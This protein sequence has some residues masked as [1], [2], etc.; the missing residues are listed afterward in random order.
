MSDHLKGAL[1]HYAQNQW[2]IFPCSEF[3]KPVFKNNL[4]QA[5]SDLALLEDWFFK[6]FPKSKPALSCARS[7]L[8]VVDVDVKNGGLD[9]WEGLCAKN[10]DPQTLMQRSASGGCHYVF[11]SKPGVLY[12]GQIA[13]G[14]DIKW[15]GYIILSPAI[16]NKNNKPY[17]WERILPVADYPEWVAQLIEKKGKEQTSISEKVSSSYIAKLIGV[18]KN[19]K[20]LDYHTWLRAGFAVH[21]ALPNEEGLSLWIDLSMGNSYKEGDEEKCR[22]MWSSFSNDKETPFTARSLP[23]LIRDCGLVVP[24]PDLEQDKR[25]L[26]ELQAQKVLEKKKEYKNAGTYFIQE[27]EQKVSWE[28]AKTVE[29]INA[30]GFIFAKLSGSNVFKVEHGD[31]DTVELKAFSAHDFLKQTAPYIYKYI[32]LTQKIRTINAGEVWLNSINRKT[33]KNFIFAEHNREGYYNL[34]EPLPTP[35]IVGEPALILKFIKESLCNGDSEKSEWLLDFLAH[36]I[37][38]PFEKVSVVP[39]HI[40][41]QGG[42]KG[43]LYDNVMRLILGRYFKCVTRMGVL[44]QQFNFHLSNK[45]LTYVDEATWGGNHKEAAALK[46]FSTNVTMTVEIKG[47]A[48]Y[49][50]KNFSRYVIASNNPKCINLEDGNRRYVVIE[51]SDTLAS[52]N[53]FFDPI[54][55]AVMA[56]DGIEVSKFHGYLLGRDISNFKAHQILKNNT[57]G[58]EAKT[59][60][61]VSGFWM[62]MMQ[63]PERPLWDKI[64]LK[65]KSVYQAFKDWKKL[66]DHHDRSIAIGSFWKKTKKLIPCVISKQIWSD[67]RNDQY[68]IIRP[69]DFFQKL[70]SSLVIDFPKNFDERPFEIPEEESLG[71]IF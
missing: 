35:T 68:W 28:E 66:V 49:E 62:D 1:A 64:G 60:D 63:Y 52:D 61:A 24:A 38:R 37:Q 54:W 59:Q 44:L 65:Q 67:K 47:G 31:D 22:K 33:I 45:L 14:I 10:S 51:G 29:G 43:L 56:P 46:T 39:V 70:C 30:Q 41:K 57:A 6:D 4:D 55:N 69:Q 13:K 11:K 71:D 20:E 15:K 21:S 3:H 9:M 7:G 50:I 48:C 18:L 5:S 26:K 23:H 36:I 53:A 19:A 25:I 17:V 42:G 40:T 27:G 34:Y 2:K 8:V 58:E 12:R 16:S 32:D